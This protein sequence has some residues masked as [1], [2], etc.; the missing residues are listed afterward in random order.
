MSRRSAVC[1]I[2]TDQPVRT[3]DAAMCRVHQVMVA[4]PVTSK[5]K[6]DGGKRRT[7]ACSVLYHTLASPAGGCTVELA[8]RVPVFVTPT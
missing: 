7:N 4:G 1:G 3:A 2:M 5:R 8:R 6:R